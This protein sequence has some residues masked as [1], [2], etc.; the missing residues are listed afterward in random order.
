MLLQYNKYITEITGPLPVPPRSINVSNKGDKSLA[1][2]SIF[3][4]NIFISF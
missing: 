1:R 3:N 2:N 4:I